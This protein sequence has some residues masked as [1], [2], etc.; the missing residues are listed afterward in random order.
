VHGDILLTTDGE[1]TTVETT[2]DYSTDPLKL[3]E[4]KPSDDDNGTSYQIT[5]DAFEMTSAPLAP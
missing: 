1:E 3:F 5:V 4:T 2:S